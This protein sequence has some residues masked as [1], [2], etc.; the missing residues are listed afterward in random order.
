MTAVARDDDRHMIPRWRPPSSPHTVLESRPFHVVGTVRSP[1]LTIP[2]DDPVLR[3]WRDS[4]SLHV[5]TDLVG[6]AI[7]SSHYA[8]ALDAAQLIIDNARRVSSQ[9]LRAAW[10]VSHH[11]PTQTKLQLPEP[12]QSQTEIYAHIRREKRILRLAP[13]DP[14]RWLELARLY[15]LLGQRRSAER[16]GWI[17]LRLGSAN[18][19][20]LRFSSRLFLHLDDPELAHHVISRDPLWRTD[21]WI[22][23]AE[24]A[25]ASIL[26]RAS[27]SISTARKMLKRASIS[28]FH[29]SEL[30]AAVGRL[31]FD[32]AA[33]KR[34]R[35]CFQAA[36]KDPTENVV[37]QAAWIGRQDLRLD[38]LAAESTSVV[39]YEASAWRHFGHH[40]WVEA[41][42]AARAWLVDQP[43]SARPATFATHLG[44]LMPEYRPEAE[45]IARAGL[46]ANPNHFVLTN[47]LVCMLAIAGMTDD[48]EELLSHG[49]VPPRDSSDFIIST[50]TRGLLAI[51][52]NHIADGD[53][54]YE[55]AIAD[56]TRLG[57]GYIAS[58]ASAYWGLQRLE[59]GYELPADFNIDANDHTEKPALILARSC[60]RKELARKRG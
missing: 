60:L 51:R 18:R 6:L 16:A 32:N 4:P 23:A 56:A 30:N 13:K 3:D 39:S 8:P 53:S 31:E 21:P 24:I 43:F 27:K 46:R 48:A 5:A 41:F 36:L 7:V 34:A 50:A 40:E 52:R 12:L 37:A 17:A 38:E 29:L 58:L 11:D 33:T 42:S 45:Q 20:I 25:L 10:A 28:Q 1:S 26:G 57:F 49:N 59:M 44:V 2:E 55:T 22:A 47:N 15:T 54:L 35:K 19:T 14:L 9:A